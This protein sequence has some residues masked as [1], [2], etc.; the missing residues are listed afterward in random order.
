M[1][2]YLHGS[3]KKLNRN[4]RLGGTDCTDPRCH[5]KQRHNALEVFRYLRFMK[6]LWTNDHALGASSVLL[7][8]IDV[9]YPLT[10]E[11]HLVHLHM[12]SPWN[13]VHESTQQHLSE[14]RAH[15]SAWASTPSDARFVVFCC[16]S[17]S[18]MVDRG[19]QQRHSVW[20]SARLS[21]AASNEPACMRTETYR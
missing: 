18:Q 9:T 13:H 5:T 16:F 6:G 10:H 2:T 19:C 20:V 1:D 12:S 3:C 17:A 15:N 14:M 11:L 8:C 4:L 21:T 7:Q